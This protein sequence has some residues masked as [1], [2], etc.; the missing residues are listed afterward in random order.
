MTVITWIQ[1]FHNEIMMG[2]IISL[3]TFSTILFLVM[4]HR[5]T[6]LR[7]D[8]RQEEKRWIEKLPV[9]HEITQQ[10]RIENIEENQMQKQ[11]EEENQLIAT[12]LREIFP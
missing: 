4:L 6:M 5:I 8:I 2:M 12:V 10:R 1:A 7:R 9:E 11:E 3:Q